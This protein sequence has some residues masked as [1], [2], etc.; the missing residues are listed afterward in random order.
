MPKRTDTGGSIKPIK[1]K[2]DY[3][4]ALVNIQRLMDAKPHS[5]EEELLEILSILV[6]KY[7]EEHFPIGNPTPIEA[8]RFRMDQLDFS[9]AD[10]AE[11]LGGENRV[12]EI[13]NK[14]RKLSLRMIRNLCYQWNIPA[15]VLIG[16]Q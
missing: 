10:L 8:I 11:I 1:T 9:N 14:K 15:E 4:K 12:S 3:R 2:K 5:P 13:M 6:E 16:R 7:E